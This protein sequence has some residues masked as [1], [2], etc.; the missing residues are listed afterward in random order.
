[1]RVVTKILTSS[2]VAKLGLSVVLGLVASTASAQNGQAMNA[3]RSQTCMGLTVELSSLERTGPGDVTARFMMRNITNDDMAMFVYYGGANGKN[4]FLIDDSG[5]EWPKKRMA[6][7]GNRRQAL[8]AGI[9][10]RYS[11]VFHIA[12]GGGDARVFQ[13]IE[14][15]QLL[16][17]TG[18]GE[19]G[20]CKFQFA[21]V[22]LG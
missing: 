21:D 2:L 19:K 11:L 22:P 17:L 1:M 14:W 4:T 20:W 10:T 13:L 5:A 3:S 15:V 16:P 18:F 12:E 6:G 8:M 9:N 7:N